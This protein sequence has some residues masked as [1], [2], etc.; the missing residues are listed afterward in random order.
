V[1]KI[2]LAALCAGLC[3]SCAQLMAMESFFPQQKAPS[4]TVH[5]LLPK[6]TYQARAAQYLDTVFF[7]KPLDAPLAIAEAK[8]LEF[9]H[10]LQVD[11][12][13]RKHEITFHIYLSTQITHIQQSNN[14]YYK[15]VLE[16]YLKERKAKA[17]RALSSPSKH[18]GPAL[19][20]EENFQLRHSTVIES[21]Y[22]ELS[23]NPREFD[24][25]IRIPS[26]FTHMVNENL[27]CGL[28]ARQKGQQA[29][30]QTFEKLE[31]EIKRL[32]L[33]ESIELAQAIFDEI[34]PLDAVD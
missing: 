24:V 28:L 3:L 19:I 12:G 7:G 9:N 4:K 20:D 1:K 32:R 15:I 14:N 26:F 33:I 34:N 18:L 30:L 23:C 8:W 27:E 5:G 16:D 13:L 22:K 31:G 21:I 6:E 29:D 11:P 17:F 2:N 10:Q 25:E